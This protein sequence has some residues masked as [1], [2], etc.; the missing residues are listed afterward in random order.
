MSQLTCPNCHS[1]SIAVAEVGFRNA[2]AIVVGALL[3]LMG[4][5]IP[6][7]NIGTVLGGVFF[8]TIAFLTLYRDRNYVQCKNCGYRWETN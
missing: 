2:A 8:I 4:V 6:P 3:I 7:G 5:M 1:N